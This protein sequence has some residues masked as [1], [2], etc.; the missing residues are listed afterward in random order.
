M[1]A[2]QTRSDVRS[3]DARAI[4]EDG[5]SD[6]TFHAPSAVA[7]IRGNAVGHGAFVGCAACAKNKH[8][9][10]DAGLEELMCAAG[11]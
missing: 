5:W 8:R 11:L 4:V 1:R 9:R 3:H 2:R 10:K 6:R 7:A